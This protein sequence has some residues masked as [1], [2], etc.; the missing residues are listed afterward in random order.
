MLEQISR[1]FNLEG[2]GQENGRYGE[3]AQ[4]HVG[5]DE[6]ET[7]VRDHYSRLLKNSKEEYRR[8]IEVLEERIDEGFLI[9]VSSDA[10]IRGHEESSNSAGLDTA[11]FRPA[12]GKGVPRSGECGSC[13]RI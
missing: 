6:V 2:K 3:P 10:T 9:P 13:R 12:H 1:Q 4:D 8:K 7:Q 5:P 11:V